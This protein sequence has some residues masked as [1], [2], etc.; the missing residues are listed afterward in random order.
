MKKSTLLK[1]SSAILTTAAVASLDSCAPKKAARKNW[2]GNVDFSSDNLYEPATIDELK[3]IIQS[4]DVIKAQGTC[5]SFNTIADSKYGFVRLS[6]MNQVVSLDETNMT[7]TVQ[8][9]IRY[10]ELCKYLESKGYALHNLAS[11]PHISVGG[12]IATATHGSGVKNQNLSSA[13][14]G[15]KVMNDTG[16]VTDEGGR[17]AV[18]LGGLG[19]ITEVTLAI[20]PTYQ[21]RQYVYL[22]MSMQNLKEHFNEVMSNGY[23]VSLFTDWSKDIN[24][25]WVKKKVTPEDAAD[26]PAELFGAAAATKD[27]HPIESISAVNCTPQ[28]G[29][30]GPW[31]ERLP[32]FKLDFTP[33][34]GEELQAEYFVALP[35]GYEAI[36]AIYALRE[37]I[38]PLLQISEVRTIAADKLLMSPMRGQD[39]LAIHFTWKKDWDGVK[40]VLPMI[41]EALS[42]YDVTPHWGKL[43]TLDPK[44]LQS[45]YDDLD[46]YKS[47][48][49][50]FDEKGKFVND[51]LQKNLLTS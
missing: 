43:F 48:M 17:L 22:H 27:M 42:R 47:Q 1:L 13:V 4:H 6:K 39:T 9:G 32:H 50:R 7:V 49:K 18:H 51:F 8:A 2:A 30:V 29:V 16:T 36:E 14:V 24:Q 25:V 21:V 45:R 34:A 3:S 31:H 5:H 38:T 12:S 26:A 15:M 37:K 33:S 20:Q 10:G 40:A 11:L 28:M 46:E 44:V 35:K 19:I 41:E 23:S